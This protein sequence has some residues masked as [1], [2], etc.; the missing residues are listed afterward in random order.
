MAKVLFTADLHGNEGQYRKLV[1]YAIQSKAD[2]VVI[3]GDL[4]PKGLPAETYILTQRHFLEDRLP[5]L[6][7]PL[8]EKNPDA[9]LFLMLGNDD[10]SCNLNVLEKNNGRLYEIMHNKR[11]AL[12]DGYELVGYG[13][14]PITPFGIKDWEKFDLTRIPAHLEAEYA[15]RKAWNYNLTGVISSPIGFK[16]HTFDKNSENVD[17]VQKDL[18]SALFLANYEKTI[19][20][21]HSPPSNTDLDKVLFSDKGMLMPVSVGS[22]AIR[23]FIEKHQP[24]ATLHGHIHESADITGNFKEQIGSTTCISAANYDTRITLSVIEFDLDDVKKAQR[25]RL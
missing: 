13:S 23:E 14:V 15:Q 25:I 4:A 17:S 6:V 9:R 18:E 8:K 2:F 11:F 16:R 24:Y 22:F 7:A 12:A 1:K 19:Y 21:M 3:G 5:R 20:A 10:C